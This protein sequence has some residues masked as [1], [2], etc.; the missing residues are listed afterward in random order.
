MATSDFPDG[1][2]EEGN[3]NLSKELRSLNETLRSL[4]ISLNKTSNHDIF[5]KKDYLE[6]SLEKFGGSLK[7]KI[8]KPMAET[9]SKD[10]LSTKEFIAKTQKI[11]DQTS[12]YIKEELNL[13]D[14]TKKQMAILLQAEKERLDF[15][16][17][18]LQI[19]KNQDYLLSSI[20]SDYERSRASKAMD[21]EERRRSSYSMQPEDRMINRATDKAS[22][23]M[24]PQTLAHAFM[25]KGGALGK[26][27]GGI[28]TLAGGRSAEQYKS[29]M[30]S[31]KS[32][33][34]ISVMKKLG[35]YSYDTSNPLD[36]K[37]LLS[38]KGEY[39]TY[40]N[41]EK[42]KVGL[43]SGLSELE[44][45]IPAD[46]DL[47]R[48][49]VEGVEF[50]L[51]STDAPS[52]SRSSGFNNILQF[53]SGKKSQSS[54]KATAFA[55]T[56]GE[57][58]TITNI[59]AQ[60]VQKVLGRDGIGY[61]YLGN[62]LEKYLDP[63]KKEDKKEFDIDG[64]GSGGA[65]GAIV[66][67]VLAILGTGI[68]LKKLIDLRKE[69]SDARVQALTDTGL[70]KE[71][72]IIKNSNQEQMAS[73]S[74]GAITLQTPEQIKEEAEYKKK[75]EKIKNGQ[76]RSGSQEETYYNIISGMIKTGE[77]KNDPVKALTSLGKNPAY[78]DDIAKFHKG[79]VV[80][81][82][83]GEV[84]LP[85]EESNYGLS[86]GLIQQTQEGG[87][88]FN[89]NLPSSI[90]S[91]S[92]SSSQI[93]TQKMETLLEQLLS[94]INTNLITAVKETKTTSKPPIPSLNISNASFRSQ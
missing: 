5:S 92:S 31:K 70:S 42:D 73:L 48:G 64:G 74:L 81:L 17:Q 12:Q 67:G 75:W 91:M 83:E 6:K 14:V 40:S 49:R 18:I 33:A 85:V 37:D 51:K 35:L 66:A 25:N 77:F 28:N 93:N 78:K 45:S 52:E 55:D 16:K 72:A 8:Y 54:Q 20:H 1:A 39:D 56:G 29:A 80:K 60:Q 62:L 19:T 79:G 50:P 89:K 11:L 86:S 26:I 90:S 47:A 88:S 76:L 87:M 94:A 65:L 13:R 61:I 3:N 57:S 24:A 43:R 27:A 59:T 10:A 82:Q 53:P 36:V 38:S 58:Y 22:L 32:D 30:A 7:E 44:A 2:P 68:F 46:L 15:Q 41:L 69:E 84:V 71:D 9:A 21:Y 4:A 63:S 34:E 23:K